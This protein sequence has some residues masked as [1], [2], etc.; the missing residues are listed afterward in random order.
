LIETPASVPWRHPTPGGEAR[1]TELYA[2]LL[3]HQDKALEDIKRLAEYE[4]K[5]GLRATVLKR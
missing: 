4:A 3:T 2:R 5:H 1:M